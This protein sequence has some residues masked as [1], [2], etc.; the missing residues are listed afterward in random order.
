[1]PFFA[2]LEPLVLPIHL[3]DVGVVGEAVEERV[4]QALCSEYLGPLIEG[5]I[6]GHQGGGSLIAL[7]EDLEEKLGPCF[8]KAARSSAHPSGFLTVEYL[9]LTCHGEKDHTW[10]IQAGKGVHSYRKK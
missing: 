9:C 7:A 4:G 10:V 2:L 3:K 8:G 5:N 6:G 1:M